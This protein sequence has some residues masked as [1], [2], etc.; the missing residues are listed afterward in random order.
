MSSTVGA[1]ACTA[2][3]AACNWYGPSFVPRQRVEDQRA[4]RGDVRA[5]PTHAVLV[6]ERDERT[7][8]AGAGAAARVGE[9]HQREQPGHLAVVGERALDLAHQADRLAR[10]IGTLELVARGRGVPLVE[11]EV[12]D[13]QHRAQP[14]V[15]LRRRRHRERGARVRGCVASPG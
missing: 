1:S 6:G 5:V 15:V 3:I 13:M 4:A 8:G 2:A 7:V 11:D 12:E 14:L 9:Q 10:E